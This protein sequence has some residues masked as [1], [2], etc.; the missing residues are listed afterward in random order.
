VI[1]FKLVPSDS[2]YGQREG[3]VRVKAYFDYNPDNDAYIPCREAGLGFQKGDI[4]H[5]V[6][7]VI[8]IHFTCAIKLF[9]EFI[10]RTTLIGGKLGRK[11]IKQLGQV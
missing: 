5:I 8:E 11:L 7:Q 1:T 4:L 9:M 6:S 3:K 2:K 10:Y